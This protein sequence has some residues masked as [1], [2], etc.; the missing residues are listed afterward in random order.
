MNI[1]LSFTFA[2][3][4]SLEFA[5]SNP[6]SLPVK[7]RHSFQGSSKLLLTEN[8][9]YRPETATN[10]NAEGLNPNLASQLSGAAKPQRNQQ[11]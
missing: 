10:Y 1:L 7:L 6:N 11:A 4:N 3:P 5:L 9:R 8:K 2:S